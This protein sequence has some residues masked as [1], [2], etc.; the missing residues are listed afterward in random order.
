MSDNVFI[1]GTS[2]F[3]AEVTEYIEN[4]NFTTENKIEISGYFS[5]NDEEH[6]RYSYEAPLLGDEKE[7]DLIQGSNV[8]VAI[9]NSTIREK[10]FN[11]FEVKKCKMRSF[12][13]SSCFVSVRSKIEDGAILCPFVTITANVNIGVGFHANIY[14]Y[15]AHDCVIGNYVTFSPGV[16]CNGNVEIGDN[17]FIGTGA[18]IKQGKNNKPL[19]IGKNAIIAAGAVVTKDVAEGLTVFGS[20]AIEFTKENL[21][22][23]KFYN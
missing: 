9:S 6:N 14:S 21:K 2:G 20:P 5:S 12:I 4:N 8:I 23:K 7:F 22:K 18:I 17:V 15:V 19:K 13:H 1:V 11:F 16:K 3:S 10:L